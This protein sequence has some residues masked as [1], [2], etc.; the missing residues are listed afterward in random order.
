MLWIG[1][2]AL[3]AIGLCVY[4]LDTTRKQIGMDILFAR[5]EMAAQHQAAVACAEIHAD[6]IVGGL[7]ELSEKL[8]S[9]LTI[10]EE[11]RLDGAKATKDGIDRSKTVDS[12]AT[13]LSVIGHEI[14]EIADA[15]RHRTDPDDLDGWPD[16]TILDEVT[17]G[18]AT[19]LLSEIDRANG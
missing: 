1:L 3:A 7:D 13:E 6:R 2:V 18:A 14:R 10:C 4:Q 8:A 16:S 19:P 12:I 9:L 15:H 5:Q 17:G 11:H